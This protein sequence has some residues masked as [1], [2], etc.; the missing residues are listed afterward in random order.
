MTNDFYGKYTL[1]HN[2][3][4]NLDFDV[5]Y[6]TKQFDKKSVLWDLNYFKYYFVKTHEIIFNENKLEEDFQGFS[7]ALLKLDAK[8]FM[9]RDFQA[10]NIMIYNDEPWYIDFQ[11]GRRAGYGLFS[12]GLWRCCWY[13]RGKFFVLD[14]CVTYSGSM[15]F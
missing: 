6:P 5:A 2:P 10:R 14:G 12:R 4:K 3:G 13:Q 15:G 1:Q 7:D 9:Y 11:G 8:Y